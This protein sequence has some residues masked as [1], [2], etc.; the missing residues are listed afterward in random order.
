M[1]PSDPLTIGAELFLLG[2]ILVLGVL[3]WLNIR[4]RR[5]PSIKKQTP[6]LSAPLQSHDQAVLVIGAG[7]Q[8]ISANQIA[9][10]LFNIKGERLN[11]EALARRSSP[12]SV[13]WSLCST[14][15]K[16]QL[17]VNRLAVEGIS[18]A[19]SLEREPV[20]ILTFRRLTPFGYE[21]K[22]GKSLEEGQAARLQTHLEQSAR[23]GMDLETTLL[24]LMT[25]VEQLFPA[26]LIEFA[27]W[28]EDE[29]CYF[30]YRLA[31]SSGSDRRVEKRAETFGAGEGW[32]SLSKKEPAPR[33]I[34][35]P[36]H[37]LQNTLAPNWQQ[38]PFKSLLGVPLELEGELISVLTLAS[39][40]E[41][42]FQPNDAKILRAISAPM[43]Q[44]IRNAVQI[45]KEKK[46]KEYAQIVSRLDLAMQDQGDLETLAAN[47]LDFLAP[48]LQVRVL[49]FLIFDQS[50]QKLFAQKPFL[51]I[52]P[53]VVDW[54]YCTVQ[55]GSQADKT[56]QK[57]E[58]IRSPD[59]TRDTRLAALGLNN[60]AQTAGIKQAIFIPL[61]SQK[62]NIGYLAAANKVEGGDF[63][64]EDEAL[65]QLLATHISPILSQAVE[66]QAARQLAERSKIFQE[67]ALSVQSL[68]SMEEFLTFALQRLSSLFGAEKAVIYLLDEIRGEL[69]AHKG[70]AIGFQGCNTSVLDYLSVADPAFNT[71]LS[72]TGAELLIRDLSSE[73]LSGHSTGTPP[74]TQRWVDELRVRSLMGIPLKNGG[75]A[76]GELFFGSLEP[77]RFSENELNSFREASRLLSF[78]IA[79]FLSSIR[80]DRLFCDS[81]DKIAALARLNQELNSAPDVQQLLQIIRQEVIRL[82]RSDCGIIRLFNVDEQRPESLRILM[83]D[84]DLSISEI[85]PLEKTAWNH[86]ETFV[87]SDFLDATTES[88]GKTATS[89]PPHEGV[90]SA[91]ITPIAYQGRVI[92]LIHLH[93]SS[94]AHFD[95]AACET[96]EAFAVQA[97]AALGKAA[98]YHE[99]V[100]RNQALHQRV[101][102]LTKLCET[103]QVLPADTPLES[104]LGSIAYAIQSATPFDIVLISVYEKDGNR[105]RRVAGAGIPPTT[106]AE[107][108]IHSPPWDIVEHMLQPEFAANSC[109]FI[110][111][112]KMPIIPVELHSVA[113]LSDEYRHQGSDASLSWHPD[114]LLLLPLYDKQGNPLGLIS[115]DAPRDGLR[116]DKFTLETLELLGSQ[117]AFGIERRLKQP[118]YERS[119]EEDEQISN[120]SRPALRQQEI[121]EA[122]SFQSLSMRTRRINAGLDIAEAVS[123]QTSRDAVLV[124]LGEGLLDRMDFDA[125]FIAEQSR[126]GPRLLHAL[127][128]IPTGLKPDVMLGQ[129]NPLRHC[130]LSGELL[131]V[132]NI[133]EH[134]EWRESTLLKALDARGFIC[135]AIGKAGK[136]GVQPRSS[137]PNS[138]D[139]ALLAISALPLPAI[140]DED[141]LL[142]SL[143]GRQASLTLQSLDLLK[144][145]DRRLR[146]VNLLMEFSRQLNSLDPVNVLRALVD[147]ARN[148]VPSA[149][150]V[151]VTLWD[152]QAQALIP[153]ASSGYA[154]ESSLIEIAFR[155][156][157][158]LAGQVFQRRQPCRIEEVDFVIHHN[159]PS[160]KLMKYRNAAGG[161]LPVSSLVVPIIGTIQT[162]PLGVL[163][164]DSTAET[165]AFA[166][167][168]QA[169]IVSLAQQTAL[170]LENARF[171]QASEQRS[172]QLEALTRVT[173]IITSSLQPDSLIEIALDQLENILPFNT[174]T[175]WL[176]QGNNLIVRAAKGFTDNE[177]RLGI[178]V[179]VTDSTLFNDMIQSGQPIYV[180]D[181]SQDDR[182][183]SIID[184]KNLSW[185]GLPLISGGEKTGVIALEKEEAGYYDADHIR[186]ATTFAGQVAVSLANASLYQESV[187]H[188]RELNLRAQR[189]AVLNQLSIELSASLDISQILQLVTRVLYQFL[190]S[191]GKPCSS[192]G[193]ILFDLQGNPAL[194]TEYP[195]VESAYTSALPWNP[196]FDHLS[197]SFGIYIS[198]E[199]SL[200]PDLATLR[201]FL[202]RV[203][204]R[205]LILAPVASGAM[206]H[207]L[208]SIHFDQ[209]S[210][211]SAAEID[212][213]RTICN[214][215]AIGLQNARLFAETRSLTEDLEQRI[216]ERTGELRQERQRAETLLAIITELSASLELDRVL[217]KT[218]NVLGD[219]VDAEQ[220]TVLV[221]R[222]G[223]DKLVRLASVGYAFTPPVQESPTP[224]VSGEGLAGW[225]IAN[226][227]A[228][229]IENILNDA[230]WI[231]LPEVQTQHRSAL[232]VPLLS[233][234]EAIGAM[235]LFHHKPAHFT[236]DQLELVQAAANQVA[237]AVNN[238]ELYRLIR[239]QA[240]NLSVVLHHQRIETSR[241]KAI[242]ESIADGVLVTDANGQITLFNASAEKNLSL[243]R[244]HVLGKSLEEFPGLFGKAARSWM[245]TI[246][247]WSRNPA[248][249]RQGDLFAE[250]IVLDNGRILSVL[251][252]PVFGQ[253]TPERE[254]EFLGTVSIFQ[255]ITHQVEVE[256]LKS[257][258]VATVS[259]ELR[260]PMTSIKGYVDILLMGAAGPLS[261]QQTHFLKV[262]KS[263]TERLGILVNDLLEISRIESGASKL[264]FQPVNLVR[265]VD[266]AL[267]KI[268]ERNAQEKKSIV[269]LKEVEPNLP[270]VWGDFDRLKQILDNILD[271]AYVY[272]YPTG[273][274]TARLSRQG[275]DV[276]VDVID[277][278]A[279]VPAAD[280]PHIFERFFRGETSLQ[281]GVA[282]TGLGLS[283][284]Q[285][286]VEMHHGK[287]WV[288]SSGIPGEGTVCSFTIPSYEG[289]ELGR[290]DALI[291]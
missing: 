152:P 16:A 70:S 231:Q 195:S 114:D 210:T 47:L 216:L 19:F 13:F 118:V 207:G 58:T 178:T 91:L 102:T 164:L 10:E 205:F 249:Y 144:E 68:G 167:E 166:P 287:I 208:L 75:R 242:L 147:T 176:R 143:L 272:N 235:L 88:G 76:L 196:V 73:T 222:P 89:A 247:R 161:N 241:S 134:Q 41:G 22:N 190:I 158:G 106:M 165:H 233:G 267:Q 116:P 67:I 127:G 291:E 187:Q 51:G 255:D 40:I 63:Q 54:Y 229:L 103:F 141:E 177:E 254:V 260:T 212:L 110:P 289:D 265:L 9:R 183:P 253:E 256:R 66:L 271:N 286:L 191:S 266:E 33:L 34:L 279:G 124:T 261:D 157:E 42:K 245:E 154:E 259:H 181:V 12:P 284:A 214:Q 282:G 24:T 59:A 281:L 274:I 223:Q 218:L 71:R 78:G 175:L 48:L 224:F 20:K 239:E 174:G 258:F 36:E 263:N 107:L 170:A 53:N 96:A 32:V 155:P 135:L 115:V 280:Q 199:V 43:A 31:G 139:C 140:S 44:M 244:S 237:V 128:R 81:S 206:L 23:P 248:L 18:H 104:L 11:L 4:S 148:V 142:L 117:A 262:V 203:H 169:L 163:S 131:I 86:N 200:E 69:R 213:L 61:L 111:Y 209:A 74:F 113:L 179:S 83:Q 85:H 189:L 219:V 125:I 64:K 269:L 220:I 37:E 25:W 204:T 217:G 278:G 121:E 159:L 221:S 130:L 94:P 171:Y 28:D 119:L 6:L 236:S 27:V 60:L 180:P 240:E 182:F 185:L 201:D 288:E 2:S 45:D 188:A 162:L 172:R 146:E 238:A 243:E 65:L 184:Y 197:E 264:S 101:D 137:S 285:N 123:C 156:G 186:I 57:G 129:R 52:Q 273:K 35:E 105:L 250:R 270:R 87:I 225:I 126:G 257:E 39:L 283:I 15:G 95:R 276:R 246:I 138:P 8:V 30:P 72:A 132:P 168:D 3:V 202:E 122:L 277:T 150:M 192:V 82:T 290:E 215:A 173:K 1:I 153:I 109:Y 133:T 275:K 193:A 120:A 160:A 211:L 99:Q 226:R 98:R 56:L 234:N 100:R 7:G 79:Y 232:G 49:G 227:Q 14:E 17:S 50:R 228:V 21:E 252:A 97:A 77:E 26:D 92:G 230:R 62:K 108:Q 136:G 149:Q 251:L 90:R 5:K 151:L 194:V 93:S 198:N 38:T 46:Q 29:R 268:A 80:G 55:E 112:E 145:T 84:G